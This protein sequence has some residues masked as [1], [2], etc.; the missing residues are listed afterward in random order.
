MLK[1]EISESKEVLQLKKKIETW[2][3]NRTS[4][5]TKM[6]EELWVRAAK[7]AELYGTSAVSR[8]LKIGY[9]ALKKQQV[10]VGAGSSSNKT[11]PSKGFVE[12]P[13]TAAFHSSPVMEVL[14]AD[15]EGVS[16]TI[17]CPDPATDWE[18]VFSGWF[19]AS[20]S[21]Q[22]GRVR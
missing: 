7:Y 14:L 8:F 5:N 13:S 2:K 10:L 4:T 15:S 1:R 21:S 6:P 20:R 9:V 12:L 16:A 18:K 11:H 19:K 17:R 22:E 3:E